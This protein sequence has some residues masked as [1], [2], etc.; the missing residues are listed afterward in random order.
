VVETQLE[1]SLGRVP[2]GRAEEV[3]VA[4]EPIWAIGT[5]KTATPGLAGTGQTSVSRL[6]LILQLVN[7]GGGP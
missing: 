1:A 2:A 7:L 4:Y 3:V 6:P 5:G